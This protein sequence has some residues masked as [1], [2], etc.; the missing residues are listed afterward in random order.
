M[1]WGWESWV[2]FGIAE[3]AVLL[4]HSSA[5]TLGELETGWQVLGAGDRFWAEDLDLGIN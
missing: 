3:S 2:H 5:Y 4:W 1:G